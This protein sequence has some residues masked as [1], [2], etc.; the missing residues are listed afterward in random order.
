MKK[1][2]LRMDDGK[3]L[4]I[5]YCLN[6]T[7]TF[8]FFYCTELRRTGLYFDLERGK[9]HNALIFLWQRPLLLQL[10]ICKCRNNIVYS[11]SAFPYIFFLQL[12]PLNKF[13]AKQYKSS[14]FIQYTISPNLYKNIHIYNDL[15]YS[16]CL[17]TYRFSST[18][19]KHTY[20]PSSKMFLAPPPPGKIKIL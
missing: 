18:W 11:I 6:F 16:I 17:E 4:S 15:I 19:Y 2:A 5:F 3:K 7:I 14:L 10:K 12:V 1:C 8:S 20:I 13:K 9:E